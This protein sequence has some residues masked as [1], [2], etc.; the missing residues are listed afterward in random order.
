MSKKLL[1]L[2]LIFIIGAIVFPVSAECQTS[3][4]GINQSTLTIT[5]DENSLLPLF[6]FYVYLDNRIAQSSYRN[7]LGGT[8]YRNVSVACGE[9]IVIPINDGAHTIDIRSGMGSRSGI[10]G[11]IVSNTITFTANKSDLKFYIT[12][13]D[14]Q[15]ITL[16]QR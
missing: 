11:N 5:R 14:E 12:M 2:G 7:V 8:S 9:T 10:G 15:N 6:R 3:G 16:T 13:D 1:W 4:S